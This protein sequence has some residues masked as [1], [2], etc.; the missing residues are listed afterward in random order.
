MN[1]KIDVYSWG[2]YVR[3]E[4][5][6]QGIG[7]ALRLHGLKGL[8]AEGKKTM[9]G[10]VYEGNPTRKY[11]ES[12]GGTLVKDELGQ[13]LYVIFDDTSEDV[14]LSYGTYKPHGSVRAVF[15]TYDIEQSIML[16]EQK[17]RAR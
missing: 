15:Y 6:G 11:Y 17:M 2:F 5:R 16:L 14:Y 3:E 1:Q 4:F 10:A 8:K 13:V 12:I 9:F 7:T